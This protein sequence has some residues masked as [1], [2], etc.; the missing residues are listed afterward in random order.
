MTEEWRQAS[1]W[2]R[3]GPVNQLVAV[4]EAGLSTLR[5]QAWPDTPS[6]LWDPYSRGQ[7]DPR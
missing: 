6:G 3:N 5:T 2:E 1:G 4:R 7:E